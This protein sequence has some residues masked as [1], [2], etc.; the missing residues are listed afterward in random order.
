MPFWRPLR[1]SLDGWWICENPGLTDISV[2]EDGIRLG[3]M[4]RWR[5]ILEDDRLVTAD[6]LL[7]AAV[8][9]VGHY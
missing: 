8:G 1:R 4:V 7:V 6:P 9:H 2:P 5:D 3:A